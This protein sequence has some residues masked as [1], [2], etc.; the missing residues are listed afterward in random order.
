MCWK[1][2]KHFVYLVP[3]SLQVLG[4][5][6]LALDHTFNIT[7]RMTSGEGDKVYDAV[8]DVINEFCQASQVWKFGE[9]WCSRG[10]KRHVGLESHT[11]SNLP[12]H[13]SILFNY[14]PYSWAF[15]SCGLLII[16]LF[17]RRP[18]PT[19]AG[20]APVLRSDHLSYRG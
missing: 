11:V 18:L 9:I 4:G 12:F 15:S 6:V 1:S 16:H 10:G 20:G 3:L 5:R 17:H 13:A 2:R 14:S 19:S 8:L 7:K